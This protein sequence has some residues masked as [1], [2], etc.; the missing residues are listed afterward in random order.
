MPVSFDEK[1]VQFMKRINFEYFEKIFAKHNF[2]FV[3]AHEINLL[4]KRKC[5]FC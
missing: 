5:G 4:S 2:I 1:L 3:F